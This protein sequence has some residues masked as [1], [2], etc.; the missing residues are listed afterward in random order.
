LD[1]LSSLEKDWLDWAYPIVAVPA[2]HREVCESAAV[3]GA[4]GEPRLSLVHR[5]PGCVGS[6]FESSPIPVLC[7]AQVHHAAILYDTMSGFEAEMDQWVASRDVDP[8]ADTRFLKAVRARYESA[9]AK[10]GPWIQT[11]S[12]ILNG[13]HYD[14]RNIAYANFAKCWQDP[15]KSKAISCMSACET[16]FPIRKLAEAVSPKVI[17]AMTTDAERVIGIS[18][19]GIPRDQVIVV[20]A[21]G[22]LRWKE[23][24]PDSIPSAKSRFADLY[25]RF[26][27]TESGDH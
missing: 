13:F 24:R 27:P 6:A 11:F 26:A 4:S 25:H 7:V 19:W 3:D 22:P 12:K 8:M 23:C 18:S 21:S 1:N 14:P 20:T 9:I 2:D 17:I 10:W 5:F 16:A 15:K